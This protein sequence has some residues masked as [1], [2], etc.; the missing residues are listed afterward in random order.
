MLKFYSIPYV[1]NCQMSM[2]YLKR[3]FVKYQC[4]IDGDGLQNTAG[5]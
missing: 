2:Q 3:S 1:K 5:Y 4:N